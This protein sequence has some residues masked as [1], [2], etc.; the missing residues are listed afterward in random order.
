MRLSPPLILAFLLLALSTGRA[1]AAG[2]GGFTAPGYLPLSP[3]F[4]VN[5]DAPRGI[6]FMQVSMQAYVETEAAAEALQ[7]HMPVIRNAMIMLL[8]GR[9]MDEALQMQTREQWRAAALAEIQ[10]I[11]QELGGE[12]GVSD[13]FFTDFIIQ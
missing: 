4:V 13:L 5:L 3:P 12:A 10:R 9:H 8:S 1:L 6:H 11:L 7:R 2:G